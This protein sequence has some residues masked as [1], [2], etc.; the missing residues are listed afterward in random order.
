MKKA[1]SL[2]SGAGGMDIGIRDAG[3]DILAE[4]ELDSWNEKA[5]EN[6]A[7]AWCPFMDAECDG[8]GNRHH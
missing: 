3:F 1:I 6:R 5:A 2:F 4:I 8:G 7:K